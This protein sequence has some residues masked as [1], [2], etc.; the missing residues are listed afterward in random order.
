MYDCVLVSGGSA[1]GD[2]L[3]SLGS[4]GEYTVV[5]SAKRGVLGTLNDVSDAMLDLVV[6]LVRGVGRFFSLNAGER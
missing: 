6:S 1:K 5:A 3:S 4:I 2:R